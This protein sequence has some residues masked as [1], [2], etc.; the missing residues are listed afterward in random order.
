MTGRRSRSGPSGC[1]SRSTGPT[2]PTTCSTR[3][4]SPTPSTTRCFAS[5]RRSRPSTPSCAPPTAPPSAS[6]APLVERAR[7]GHPPPPDDLAGQRLLGRGAGGVGGAQRPHPA[8]GPHGRLHRRDQ[9][10]RRRGEPHLRGRPLGRGRDPRQRRHRRGHHRQPP[11]DRRRAARAQGQGLARGDGNPGR[12]LPA[13]RRLHQGEPGARARGRAALRQPAERRRR[14]APPARSQPHAAAPAPH[15][16]LRR[17]AGRGPA[18]AR[19]PTGSC[20]TCSPPGASRSSR[21]AQRFDV[22]GRGAGGDRRPAR[23]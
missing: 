12:G 2:T 22:A 19:A 18:G 3:R 9:D 15:V 10:R 11:H 17:R 21:T 13:L 16:R 23:S 4:R 7:Q 8:R 5:C 14:R 1:A 20:S 6:G